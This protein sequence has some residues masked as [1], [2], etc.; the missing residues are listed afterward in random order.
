[1]GIRIITDSTSDINN[2]EAQLMG[3]TVIPLKVL[4]GNKEYREGININMKDFYKK[5]VET[6]KLPTTSQPAQDDFF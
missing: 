1:M 4:F 3:I 2:E 5:L 6:D